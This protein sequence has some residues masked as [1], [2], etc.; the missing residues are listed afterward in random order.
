[1]PPQ[2]HLLLTAQSVDPATVPIGMAFGFMLPWAQSLP[3]GFGQTKG[4][5]YSRA[6]GR[7][8]VEFQWPRGLSGFHHQPRLKPDNSLS[9]PS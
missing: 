3:R 8:R 7:D 9:N 2:V 5:V 4:C 1:M 6:A